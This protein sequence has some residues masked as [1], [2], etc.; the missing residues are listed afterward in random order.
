M[1][2]PEKY[3]KLSMVFNHHPTVEHMLVMH[4]LFALYCTEETEEKF[5]ASMIPTFMRTAGFIL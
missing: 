5:Y 3:R 4:R 2:D 1:N